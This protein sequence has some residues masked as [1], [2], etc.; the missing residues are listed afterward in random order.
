MQVRRV[1]DA[2]IRRQA[3]WLILLLPLSWLYRAITALRNFAYDKGLFRQHAAPLRIISVGNIVAGG[4]GKTP[5]VL[6]LASQCQAAIIS[7]GY[8]HSIKE[9]LLLGKEDAP[10]CDEPLLLARRT[11]L[12]VYVCKDRVAAARRAAADG[13]RLAILDDGFQHRRL[14]RD[15]DVVLVDGHNPFGFGRFLPCGYLRDAPKRLAQASYIVAT[16]INSEADLQKVQ[17]QLARYTKAPIYGAH[18]VATGLVMTDG[19]KAPQLRGLRVAA[20]CGL[21]GPERFFSLLTEQGAVLTRTLALA[22]HQ[23]IS[24]VEM[25]ELKKG[26][27]L[28]VCTEKDAVKLQPDSSLA[29]L[30]VQLSFVGRTPSI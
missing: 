8:P 25:R 11:G 24:E 1:F 27:D 2:A 30:A 23:Q 12:P 7:R 28:L 10:L 5:F 19:S 3:W 22:D 26:C 29:Y 20:F 13:C 9:P 15:V 21:A 16:G 18:L 4:T 6:W 14:A 17:L